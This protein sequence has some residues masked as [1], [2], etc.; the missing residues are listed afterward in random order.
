[1]GQ[2]VAP[3][4]ETSELA[5]SQTH[6]SRRGGHRAVTDPTHRQDMDGVARVRFHFGP[7]A[8]DGDIDNPVVD[9]LTVPHL[10]QQLCPG[11]G[12][13]RPARHGQEKPVFQGTE[14]QRSTAAG[15]LM[16]LDV[17]GE[18]PQAQH[19]TP[20]GLDGPIL[21]ASRDGTVQERQSLANTR[22]VVHL[23][24]VRR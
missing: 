10:L 5:W 9:W 14:S 17:D 23:M 12:P 4:E 15:D 21:Q 3:A 16:R 20:G 1:M 6:A 11:K 8:L 22:T 2:A 7:Q 18:R 24:T 19:L 13:S